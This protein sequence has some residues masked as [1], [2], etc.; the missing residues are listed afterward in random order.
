VTILIVCGMRTEAAILNSPAGAVV[1]QGQNGDAGLADQIEAAIANGDI[2]GVMSVGV[3]G[4]VGHWLQAGDIVV[5]SLVKNGKPDGNR[6]GD[7]AW[8]CQI[9]HSIPGALAHVGVIGYSPGIVATADAKQALAKSQGI[10]AVDME[11]WVAADVAARHR[12]PFAAVRAISDPYDFD[13]PPAAL[14][15]M[16]PTGSIDLP[17]VVESLGADIGQFPDLMKLDRYSA[18]A[19]ENLA[20]TMLNIGVNFG[21]PRAP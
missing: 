3:S 7:S 4:G 19:F 16:S 18:L 12:L 13:L 11:T 14:A 10:D 20:A 6:F 1:V 2:E 5:S 21:F 17:A 8:C 9:L 15:A